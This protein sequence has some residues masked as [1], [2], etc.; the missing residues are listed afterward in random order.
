MSDGEQPVTSEKMK[1][2]GCK[3]SEDELQNN[4]MPIMHGC[5]TK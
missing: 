4:I 2:I 5:W 3:I 1:V